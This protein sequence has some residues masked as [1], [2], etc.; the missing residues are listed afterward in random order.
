[1][2]KISVIA[3]IVFCSLAF[4]ANAQETPAKQWEDPY[5]TGF[6][7]YSVRPIHTSDI[8]YK[9]TL[10]RAIDLREK[11]NLPMFSRNR[12]ISRLIIDATLAGTITPYMNDSLENGAKLSI[13]EFNALLTMPS[14]QPAYT[15]EDTLMMWQNED[16]S[17]R[18]TS[19]GGDKFFPTD[20]Y[21]MEIKEEWLF[22]KQRSRQYFDI[23]AITFYIPA[24]HPSN[25]KGIQYALASYSYK[26]LCEKLFKD[27]PKAIWFNPQNEREHK[28]LADAFDLRLFSSY[29]IKVS[30]PKDAYL[31]DIYGGDQLKGL[32]A[33]QWAA[34][35]LLEYEHNLWEF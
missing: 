3:S 25:I 13:D 23:D 20:I 28:N 5:A 33:S 10:I 11:Q 9:K 18:A 26:E 19:T 27:N 17:Y 30:N 29:I 35:E 6:N 7:K 2:N 22:D 14:D 21:Q 1:M 24:D 8:M 34:F 12:E 31:T 4:M 32:M 16:Y 15:P